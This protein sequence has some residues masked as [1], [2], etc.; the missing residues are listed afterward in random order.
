MS[1]PQFPES[2]QP[3]HRLRG[4]E[5]GNGKF[6]PRS[7]VSYQTFQVQA[8]CNPG[9]EIELQAG[10]KRVRQVQLFRGGRSGR[11]NS[12]HRFGSEQPE[13]STLEGDLNGTVLKKQRA[14][15]SEVTRNRPCQRERSTSRTGTWIRASRRDCISSASLLG[16]PVQAG[17]A[18]GRSAPLVQGMEMRRVSSQGSPWCSAGV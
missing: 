9:G 2:D 15:G 4:Q 7:A 10:R 11:V 1:A 18:E 14:R 13:S 16:H 6:K 5:R 8:S 17:A 12:A 3:C